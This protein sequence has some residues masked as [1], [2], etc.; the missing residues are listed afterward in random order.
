M[1]R[2]GVLNMSI[3]HALSEALPYIH[4]VLKGEAIVA[5]A[6]KETESIVKYLAGKRVDSGYVDGQRVNPN[7][8]NVYIAFRGQNADVV[9]P[10]SVYG[11][12]IKAFSFPIYEGSKVVGALAI[13][14]PIDNEMELKRYMENMKG[15]IHHFQSNVHTIAS[16]SQQLAATSIEID[17]QTQGALDDAL[18]TNTITN[19]IKSISRQTNLLGLN[20]S[21][22]AAR[23][24]QYGAGF[25]IVAQEVRKLSSETDNAT[26]D[27]EKALK[28]IN[29]NLSNLKTHMAQIN[30]ASNE[31]ATIVQGFSETIEELAKLTDEMEQFMYK[32]M[33]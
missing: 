31:Q 4:K 18:Q 12:E 19:F 2:K 23:A 21:I 27:I 22:E 32:V 3:L 6:D 11:V 17:N 1:L 33:N 25:N 24:G 5:V 8:N 20:A 10:K 13:G 30:M 28:N 29:T 9:I 26:D 14:L 7:D 15:I 16:Q